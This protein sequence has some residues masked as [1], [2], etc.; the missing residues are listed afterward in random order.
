L[1]IWD[2]EYSE[3][4][5]LSLELRL[6]LAGNIHFIVCGILTKRIVTYGPFHKP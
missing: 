2:N 4:V 3:G 1:V 5:E 6:E